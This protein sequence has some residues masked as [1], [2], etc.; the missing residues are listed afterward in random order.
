MSFTDEGYTQ[1]TIEGF[2]KGHSIASTLEGELTVSYR[3]IYQGG[4]G[5]DSDY[6]FSAR[7]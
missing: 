5:V 3:P 1:V 2:S 6:R 7:L 4:D